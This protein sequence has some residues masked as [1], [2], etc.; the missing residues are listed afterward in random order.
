MGASSP[1]DGAPVALV[2]D[3]LL[4]MRGAERTFA[5]IA[6]R[7]PEAPIYTLLYDREGTQGRFDGREVHTSYLQR[8]GV[9]QA[10]FRRLLPLFP[11]AARSLRFGEHRLV[12][13]SSSAFAHTVNVGAAEHVCYCHSPFRYAWFRR[14]RALAEV[15]APAR[16]LLER[17]LRRVRQSDREAARRVSRYV[18]NSAMT[19]RRLKRYWGATRP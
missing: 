6:D 13:S 1:G 18:A 17:T 2:H 15:P 5:A 4:V 19:R 10:G 14:E 7:W 11:R 8:I 3:Y 16:P 12:I 9:G